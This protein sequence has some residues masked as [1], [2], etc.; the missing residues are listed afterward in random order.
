MNTQL[1]EP[2]LLSDIEDHLSNIY[3]DQYPEIATRVLHVIE[4][5]IPFALQEAEEVW[6]EQ[7][8]L[9]ITY[10]DSLVENNR[11][12]LQT[13]FHFLDTHLTE[14][15]NSVHILPFFPHS[16]DDGFSVIDYRVINPEL[17]DWED[18][19]RIANKF[20][21]MVDLV[22][23]HVSRDSLWFYDYVANQY[24]ARDYF[25]E[26]PADTDVSLVTRPRNTPLLVPVNTH[27]GM[28][29]VWATFSEDQI[30]LNFCNPDVL[31][32]FIDI[33]LYYI[34]NGAR[35]IRLDAIAFLW[36]KLGTNC[37][38][39]DETHEVV[40]LLRD[41]INHV[42]PD[43]ILITETNVPH[44]ENL[45]YFG[46]GDEAHMVY[47][48]SLPPLVLHALNRGT[49]KYLTQWAA[50]L[51]E[52]PK[53]CSYLN[54]TASHDGIGLRALEGILPEHEIEDLIEC[55]QRFGGFV[56]MKAN[57]DGKDS[58]YEINISLFDAMQGTRRNIDQ[59]QVNRFICSQAIMLAMQGIPAFYIH[60]L[61]ATP[62]DL[63]SVELSGRTR[64]INRK[65]WLHDELQ[66]LL[67]SHNTPNYEV[68]NELKRIISIRKN[69][70]CFH[71]DCG[72]EIIDINDSIFSLLR[73]DQPGN[74]KLFAI[75]N[76]TAVP[77]QITLKDRPDLSD[78]ADW[79]DLISMQPL[80][81]ILPGITLQPYQFMWLVEM[82]KD[83]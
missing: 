57:P 61:L 62:N 51:P 28:C 36:K 4:K 21:L 55:M 13:L 38:H 81:T 23:N 54:F 10:G 75:F 26:L 68:F 43:C 63:H 25:I 76:V 8:I 52:L 30:D 69:Q 24:P 73:T 18:I 53:E 46:D 5:Y 64:S 22:I 45:S 77:Q 74:Q 7:D 82:R 33:L 78:L 49:A 66:T 27:R 44:E 6:S 48:F 60:S 72:Q 34:A 58:P 59:W 9:L 39:L 71:P 37:I 47:Q 65:K 31:I 70:A 12:P 3:P 56:S 17:G 1:D 83:S 80:Q 16:S 32:E 35:L 40:K 19:N 42:A 67:E 14:T 2:A 50:E 29:H 15:I 79:Y 41:I 20:R 11:K